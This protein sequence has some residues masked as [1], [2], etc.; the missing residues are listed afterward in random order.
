MNRQIKIWS[1]GDMDRSAKVRWTGEELQYTIEEVRLSVGDHLQS[2]YRELNPYGQVPTAELDGSILIESTAICL[3]LAE[4]HPEAQLIPYGRDSRDFFWQ[5]V[6]LTT[7]T[8]EGPIVLYLRSKMGDQ[9]AAWIDLLERPLARRLQTFA[10]T[11][12]EEGCLCGEFTLADVFAAYSLRLALQAD[13]LAPEGALP[14]YLRRLMARPAAH[15][16]GFFKSLEG[17]I[18]A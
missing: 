14:A 4:R 17:K 6:S 10:A 15:S 8:L 11:L 7:T 13:L 18:E 5:M 9:D 16:S 2:P 1:F 12:P 3:S